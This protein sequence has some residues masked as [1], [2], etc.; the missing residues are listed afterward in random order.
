MAPAQV[1]SR[2]PRSTTMSG[3][4][5]MKVRLRLSLLHH[6]TVVFLGFNLVVERAGADDGVGLL[7]RGE[8][9]VEPAQHRIVALGPIIMKDWP[10]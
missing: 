7:Q 10:R 1:M 3:L 5:Q 6:R 8:F 2:W 4:A 9:D